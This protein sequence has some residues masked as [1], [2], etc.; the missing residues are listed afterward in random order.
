MHDPGP[1]AQDIVV[2]APGAVDVVVVYVVAVVVVVAAFA[3]AAV[4]YQCRQCQFIAV[5]DDT[6]KESVD[7]PLWLWLS[8]RLSE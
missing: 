4:V 7:V 6:T 3:F 2:V 5:R 1:T 8:C